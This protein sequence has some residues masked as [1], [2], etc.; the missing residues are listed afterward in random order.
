VPWLG[1]GN[2]I[3]VLHPVG[4]EPLLRRWRQRADRRRTGG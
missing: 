3:S 2:L 1:V 4:V